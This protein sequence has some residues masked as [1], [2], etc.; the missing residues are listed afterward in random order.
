MT[1]V[2]ANGKGGT[3]KTT[4]TI[5]ISMALSEAGYRVGVSDKD[6]QG[7]ATR[8]LEEDE[9][10]RVELFNEGEDYDAVLID[11]PPQLDSR[12]LAAAL[13]LADRVL[14]VSSPSPADL[15]TSQSTA[16]LV[17]QHSKAPAHILFNQVQAGTVL[18]KGLADIAEK[19]GLPAMES[20]IA[21]RQA[22]QHA[23]LLGW[24]ALPGA[25]REEVFRAALEAT[26]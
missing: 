3:G 7:T 17:R 2:L 20:T 9:G 25:V 13:S 23:V 5:L 1:I 26:K 16:E 10:T 12:D 4:L 8:W 19:L 11:T 21:R 6:P 24:K 18:S 22:Y 14:I 15:W